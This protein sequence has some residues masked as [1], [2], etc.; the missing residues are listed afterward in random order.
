MCICVLSLYIDL[1][2]ISWEDIVAES[3]AKLVNA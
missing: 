1:T 3:E 2:G